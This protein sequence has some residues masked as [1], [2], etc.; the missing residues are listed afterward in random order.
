MRAI[1]TVRDGDTSTDTTVLVD[2]EPA[3]PLTDVVRAI[4]ARLG[5]RPAA[6][7][8]TPAASPLTFAA[9]GLMDG[10]VLH[11]G[12]APRREPAAVGIVDVRYVGGPGAGRLRRLTVGE[13][14][15][16]LD[17]HGQAAFGRDVEGDP[18]GFV[19]LGIHGAVTVRANGEQ[20]ELRLEVDTIDE[21][22]A[23]WPPHAQLH[24]GSSVLEAHPVALSD[25]D[26][27]PSADSGWLDFNRP[28]RLLPPVPADTFRRPAPPAAPA[29]NS[30]PWITAM[31]PALMGVA[32]A[33]ML[34]Q[35]FYLMFAFMSPVMM[36][37]SW[38]SSR[39]NG[40]Q[41]HRTMMLTWKKNL[42]DIDHS[43]ELA[44][45][46]EQHR[47]RTNA[48][49]AAALL[50]AATAPTRRLWERRAS[51]PDHL[52]VRFGTADLPSAVALEEQAELEHRRHS[53]GVT[54]AVPVTLSLA[55]AG[56]I[57]IAGRG[58]WARRSCRWLVGQLAV[59]QSPRDLQVY[60][61]SAPDAG[62]DWNW[63]NWLPHARPGLGQ[64]TLSLT[65]TDAESLGRRVAELGQLVTERTAATTA[66]AARTTS[67]SPDVLVVLDGA[68]R[69]RAMPGIVA[70]LRDGAAVGVHVVCLDDEERQLPE[71]CRAVVVQRGDGELV[72]KQQN[73][74]DI[75]HVSTDRID[76]NWFDEVGRSL[77]PIHDVSV[78]DADGLLPQTARL[79]D[80]LGMPEPT[81]ESVASRWRLD[82][83]STRATIG[84][85][86]DGPFAI[87]LVRDGPHGLVAGTTG[88]GK[89]EFLQTLVASLA[90]ANRP[91]EMTFVLVDYKGGA[92]FSGCVDLPHTVGIVT[93]LDSHLVQRALGSLR[94]ELVRREHILALAGAKDLED[95]HAHLGR[96]G[97]GETLPRLAIVID[98]FAAMAKEL[99][100]FVAGLIGIAQR[101]R[102]LGVHLV[103]ATQR[104]S[105]VISPEIRANTNLR[106][107]LRMTD[108]GE[109]ADVID[110]PD[111]ARISKAIPGRAYARLGHAS[112]I[113]FQTAR[114]G[115]ASLVAADEAPTRP[116]FVAE[117]SWSQFSQP[118]PVPPRPATATALTTDL[119]VLV[120]SLREAS[121]ILG[122]PRQHSPWLPPLV[123]SL[124]L[125]SL[126]ADDA[127]GFGW[128]LEDI[129]SRQAQQNAAI[130]LDRFGHLYVVGAPGSGRSQTLRTIA[131]SAARSNGLSDVHI[132]G[133]DCGNGALA[134]L[135]ALPH[136]GAVTQRSQSERSTRLLDKLE[137][138][139]LR[140]HDLLGAGNF[141]NVAEQ[142]RSGVDALP[143][144][145]LFIDRW[146]NFASTLGEVDGGRLAEVV[147]SLLRDGASAGVH[148]VISGDRSLLTSRMAVLCDDKLILR[149]TDRLDYSLADLNHK[150]IPLEI[151]AGRGFRAGSGTEVQV[152]MLGPDPA[153]QA[154]SEAVRRL[155]AELADRE[156]HTP[157]AA[158]PFRVDDLPSTLDIDQA[159]GFAVDADEHTPMWA[160]LGVGGDQLVAHGINLER[161]SPTFVVA[162]PARSG[163]STLLAVMAH[164]LLRTGTDLVLVCPRPSP[165]RDLEGAP[166]V[167]AV[168]T[169]SEIAEDDLAPLLAADGTPVVLIVDDGELVMDAPAKNWLRTY[170]RTA[171][172]NRRGLILGGNAA[173][174]CAG[175]AGWQ[176]D[177]K[178]NR[179]GALLSP[180]STVDGDLLGVR[181]ARSMVSPKITP[182]RA[183]V[184]LGSGDLITLQVP[185][186]GR[187]A[188]AATVLP[189]PVSAMSLR[190][191]L[192]DVELE[193]TNV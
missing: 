102:S 39:R 182:G 13:T 34:K 85:S 132:Y 80:V 178:K 131:A 108:V 175:F 51:D 43:I 133:I 65:A 83:R 105:G 191:P 71:E 123:E 107:A 146:D 181:V 76:P 1:V 96:G 125:E 50:L 176:V 148:V 164:S 20:P 16:G 18:L 40:K 106:V 117:L 31:I 82:G 166:G 119:S 116:P 163:R 167:R 84:I 144:I 57:G 95:Y 24:I 100:D 186:L 128:G 35:P 12:A 104:P 111:A 137:A 156:Q 91:D 58:D 141:A 93:D 179:R 161:D 180:Q 29:R 138:E 26:L 150:N 112:I 139:V 64:D 87:D 14:G 10:A 61:L 169:H 30:M 75:D 74:D 11:I 140:R 2:A 21:T 59:L 115:G 130:D 177:L 171:G 135:A 183:L 109:S 25:A 152:A 8:A 192:P 77:A 28:P 44:V 27:V 188:A 4:R 168:L 114:V 6:E 15:F 98:E 42:A 55:E 48:P 162:G 121:S 173:E 172:D 23:A 19:V 36:I 54:R 7:R 193:N 103:M 67:F 53:T 32:M 97:P 126:P 134:S 113:P 170:V 147:Q 149:L 159:F 3:T 99:P 94:A 143:H 124:P 22:G 68:R 66:T 89:S 52:L 88:A 165:L 127:A 72:V 120:D 145:L 136:C 46:A 142:R 41:S 158:R 190:P 184:H 78:S 17:S 63:V 38:L 86:L 129:P 155:G 160:M 110:I 153:G 187:P 47:R 62:D 81:G 56:V 70:L 154:Q 9:S 151:V 174:I 189:R 37:G 69:L 118:A 45:G 92:A 49:D 185:V 101:G 33:I 5:R 122:I 157:P 60:V 90:V 73:A 79:L